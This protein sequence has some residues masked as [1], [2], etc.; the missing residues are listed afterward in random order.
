[1]A[2]SYAPS[3]IQYATHHAVLSFFQDPPNVDMLKQVAQ[4]Q[5]RR[6][7]EMSKDKNEDVRCIENKYEQLCPGQAN[8]GGIHFDLS[9]V[10][11]RHMANYPRIFLAA[12][13]L[14]DYIERLFHYTRE[15]H[16]ANFSMD[17]RTFR[18]LAFDLNCYVSELTNVSTEAL[19]TLYFQMVN[20]KRC[21]D[22]HSA[23]TP[24]ILP[25]PTHLS[26]IAGDLVDLDD[27]IQKA[28]DALEVTKESKV[29]EDSNKDKDISKPLKVRA[30]NAMDESYAGQPSSPDFA[31]PRLEANS[32]SVAS[33]P[34]T[35]RPSTRATPSTTSI[36]TP[37]ITSSV[38]PL[39]EEHS[40][41]DRIEHS[42]APSVIHYASWNKVVNF[43]Q[44]PPDAETLMNRLR[45]GGR[46]LSHDND[47]IDDRE[48]RHKGRV[49]YKGVLFDF[50]G[51][52][53]DAKIRPKMFLTAL[54][55]KDRMK[56]MVVGTY[57]GIPGLRELHRVNLTVSSR[58]FNNL[59]ADLKDTPSLKG[60]STEA[61]VTLY[62]QI[63]NAKRCLDAHLA[64]SKARSFKQT[65]MC[66]IADHLVD[67]DDKIQA[68]KEE[69]RAAISLENG[70]GFGSIES[71]MKDLGA[72]NLDMSF[73]GRCPSPG[74]ADAA[75]ASQPNT[76]LS[77]PT[78]AVY[79][80][81]SVLATP[82]RRS[83]PA[84]LSPPLGAS[85][86][87]LSKLSGVAYDRVEQELARMWKE[88]DDLQAKYKMQREDMLAKI[89][90]QQDD[91]L[92]KI[93][94]R[95]AEVEARNKVQ[96]EMM[97]R[98]KSQQSTIETLQGRLD[99]VENE[100]SKSKKYQE[101]LEQR[102]V[103]LTEQSKEQQILISHLDIGL[104]GTTSR[105]IRHDV[106]I[107][108]LEGRMP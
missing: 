101:L 34:A 90:L 59:A 66:E 55:I 89:K 13:H 86:L 32:S 81:S 3:A 39:P 10:D 106:Q 82:T 51:K 54:F 62:F 99:A 83:T 93:T 42:Y 9:C 77:A 15:L 22:A 45:Y 28:R 7:S 11:E 92:D 52:N 100:I 79:L 49:D 50:S 18:I 46:F 104:E 91:M 88:Q 97:A 44:D 61:L 58:T 102:V 16:N 23:R 1:M 57:D 75:P 33:P 74:L 8:Y 37:R 17:G 19:V 70:N 35:P 14:K 73:D 84:Q 5:G 48:I 27:K 96:A 38:A 6:L 41:V 67:Y 36:P 68:A 72:V 4:H 108:G 53:H 85:T 94:M 87:R 26:K 47:T 64:Q 25:M 78:P 105:T 95:L 98:I 69:W 2:H 103:K 56:R 63:V 43:F 12:H 31:S 21:L 30:P 71:P 65:K 76:R 20:A 60:I 29:I 80:P 107:R 40:Y 24:T